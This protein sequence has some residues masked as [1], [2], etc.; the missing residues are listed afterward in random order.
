MEKA[1]GIERIEKL[2][3]L[4]LKCKNSNIP[5]FYISCNF[6][7]YSTNK[8]KQLVGDMFKNTTDTCFRDMVSYNMFKDIKTV[9]YA[10]DVVF[11]YQQEDNTKQLNTLG[12]SVINFKYRENQKDYEKKYYTILINT[13]LNF[14]KQE[15]DV[16]LFSFCKYEG[17]EETIEYILQKLPNNYKSKVKIVNYDGNLDK[18]LDIYS[19][20]EYVICSRFHSMILSYIF[21]QKKYV[22][23][24]SKKIDNVIE[25]LK[26]SDNIFHIEQ[27]DKKDII[28]IDEFKH[29]KT[30][31]EIKN[32]AE[33]Q[34][35]ILDKYLNC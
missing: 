28:N 23:S 27:L 18:F 17:D 14:L 13:I 4:V 11:S 33:K 6:G 5:F 9:R 12:I 1:G 19:K 34:F 3:K 29:T 30:N 32:M 26:I 24:Y 16:T 15:K 7:P 21:N 2:N 8:Y 35:Y 25:D 31:N 10:P 20:M 22:I